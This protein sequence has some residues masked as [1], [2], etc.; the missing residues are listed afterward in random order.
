MAVPPSMMLN[1]YCQLSRVEKKVE[2]QCVNAPGLPQSWRCKLLL[3][4]VT[5]VATGQGLNKKV[6]LE[7][8]VQDFARHLSNTGAMTRLEAAANQRKA[9]TQIYKQKAPSEQRGALPPAPKV[10]QWTTKLAQTVLNRKRLAEAVTPGPTEPPLKRQ[11]AMPFTPGA[12][13]MPVTASCSSTAPAPAEMAEPQAGSAGAIR[14]PGPLQGARPAGPHQGAR[15]FSAKMAA[16]APAAHRTPIHANALRARI[17]AASAPRPIGIVK[18]A[19]SSSFLENLAKRAKLMK[20]KSIDDSKMQL[21]TTALKQ[22]KPMEAAKVVHLYLAKH[23]GC[24]SV[25]QLCR[26]FLSVAVSSPVDEVNDFL[27]LLENLQIPNFPDKAS[28]KYFCRFARWVL[29]ELLAQG[30]MCLEAM[31]RQSIGLLESQGA[32]VPKLEAEPGNRGAELRLI[33]PEPLL[34]ENAKLTLQKSDWVYLSFPHDAE[35]KDGRPPSDCSFFE[36]EVTGAPSVGE[37]IYSVKLIGSSHEVVQ[38]LKG[39]TCRMDKAANRV[40]FVRQIEALKSL[41]CGHGGKGDGGWLRQVLIASDQDDMLAN[42]A[43]EVRIC[44]EPTEDIRWVANSALWGMVNGSQRDAIKIALSRRMTLI[45]GPPGSGKTHTALTLLRL[46]LAG[47]R[48][49]V[50]C[51][52]DSNVAVD[53]LTSGCANALVEVVRVGRPESS[54]PDLEKYNLLE[55]SRLAGQ[56]DGQASTHFWGKEKRILSRAEVVCTTCSGSDHPVL[57]GMEFPS[58]IVDEA[59]QA[60]EPSVLVPLMHLKAEG[61]VVLIGDHKQLPPMINDVKSEAEGLALPLFER[62]VGR[63]VLPVMLDVQYRMHPALADFPSRWSYN[64]LLRSGVTGRERAPPGGIRWPDSRAPVAF[65]P[66]EGRE[67]REGLSFI[68]VAEVAAIETLLESV[69]YAGDVKPEEIGVISPY[70]AQVRKI[71]R[72][73]AHSRRIK[74]DRSLSSSKSSEKGIEICSVDGFQGREKELIIVSTV[75]AN[76][77]GNVGFLADPRRLN[78]TITRA[79]RGLLVLGHFPTLSQDLTGWRPWLSWAQARGLIAGQDATE[80]LVANE[81]M[82]LASMSVPELLQYVPAVGMFHPEQ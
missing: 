82:A 13:T 68:N 5:Y 20:L 25:A 77:G 60:T 1:R 59:A 78:V 67:V 42:A 11:A 37:K 32:C 40:T 71:R 2:W 30:A 33:L 7:T 57:Q 61:S 36:A 81:F 16:R 14:P 58:L 52:A 6:A 72:A 22:A 53:N 80:P 65:L 63:G 8:A 69:I 10:L 24:M 76:Q 45:Q 18:S 74:G 49:P 34:Q 48:G 27:N 31:S 75:R 46:W 64:G 15:N 73:V 44:G 9:A 26:L 39:R 62:L 35:F 51:T 56:Q 47:G 55:R 28:Q 3:P 4:G 54:R 79:R 17:L 38:K 12:Q 41:V 43:V 50:L 70:A 23:P 66:V 21:M 29:K 19:T